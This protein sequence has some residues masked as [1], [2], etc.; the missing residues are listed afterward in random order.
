MISKYAFRLFSEYS[1]RIEDFFPDVKSDLKRAGIRMSVTEYLSNAMFISMLAFIVLTPSLSFVF[2]YFLATFLFSFITAITIS[3][4]IAVVVFLLYLGYPKTIIKEKA[5]KIDRF[6]P[7]TA[8]YLSTVLSSK[9]PLHKA[10]K[11]FSKFSGYEEIAKEISKI[12]YDVE[13]FGLDINTALER[14]IA[15]SPSKTFREFLYG[16]LST[17]RAGGNL[18]QYLKEKSYEYMQDWRRKL[19]R[20]AHSMVI[21]T[22]VYL[23]AVILGA[24][25][26]TILT[27]VISGIG[28]APANII[29]LQFFLIFGLIPAV[30]VLFIFLVKTAQPGGE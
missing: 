22:E 13:F 12:S 20:F 28:G 10:F 11:I 4:F 7:F 27:A 30:S 16:V 5:K 21:Y 24:I 23:T 18:R 25:F 26:F 9:L 6:L 15:R 3:I 2:S 19:A 8:L 1:S 14:A 29:T 17:I